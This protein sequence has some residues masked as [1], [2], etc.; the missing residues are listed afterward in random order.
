MNK[1]EEREISQKMLTHLK[2]YDEEIDLIILLGSIFTF[3]LFL[4]LVIILIIFMIE[5]F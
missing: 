5:L 2:Y 3:S 1:G 4:F